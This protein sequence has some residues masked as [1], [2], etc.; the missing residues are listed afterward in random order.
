MDQIS[1]LQILPATALEHRLFMALLSLAACLV[2]QPLL[3]RALRKKLDARPVFEQVSALFFRSVVAKLNRAGRSDRSLK[4]RGVIIAVLAGMFSLLFLFAIRFVAAFLPLGEDVAVYNYLDFIVLLL[5]MSPVWSLLSAWHYTKSGQDKNDTLRSIATSSYSNLIHHDEHGL[6]RVLARN[7]VFALVHWCFVPVIIY[8]LCGAYFTLLYTALCAVYGCA[9]LSDRG[10]GVSWFSGLFINGVRLIGQW[11]ST[12]V[13]VPAAFFTG[14]ASLGKALK[15]ACSS[16]EK[17]AF[18]SDGG[19]AFNVFAFSLSLTL[20]GPFQDMYGNGVAA[21]WV[22]PE[23]SS[24]QIKNRDLLRGIYMAIISL[25][26]FS[27]TILVLSL[28]L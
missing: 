5:C 21:R 8:V 7:V 3:Y 2:V 10:K 24:A 25:I 9:G 17:T 1:F 13:L 28:V 18:I 22:G 4:V 20:G 11:I 16:S 15:G 6:L 19:R 27:M 12:V 23:G 26:L 14:T